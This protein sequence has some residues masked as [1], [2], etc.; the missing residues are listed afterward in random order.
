MSN[1][2]ATYF[3]K[4]SDEWEDLYQSDPRFARR[5]QLLTKFIAP[6]LKQ[7][8][9]KRALDYGCGTGI[10]ARWL[11]KEGIEVVGL[12]ISPQM[13]EKARSLTNGQVNLTFTTDLA[14]ISA[15]KFDAILSLSVL[16]YI[17]D[18]ERLLKAFATSTNAGGLLIASVPNPQGVI[19]RIE[20]L[21]F[22]IRKLTRGK[23]FGNRGDYLAHQRWTMS[24]RQFDALITALGYEKV[25]AMYYNAALAVPPGLLPVLERRWW[26]ALYAGAYRKI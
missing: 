13:I 10:F 21:I 8:G 12:D 2:T 5:Y 6:L 14:Q 7:Y 26:A 24:P 3:D 17:P 22:G 23:L 1:S 4:R 18:V 11:S 9:V 19:R 16:E 15:S 20:S 25:G